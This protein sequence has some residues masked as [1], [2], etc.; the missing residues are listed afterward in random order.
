MEQATFITTNAYIRM[1]KIKDQLLKIEQTK[2]QIK[3]SKGEQQRQY[4]KCLH[5]LQKELNL[6][7]FY[8]GE[9]NGKCE[10]NTDTRSG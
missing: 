1:I 10:K 7:Y 9:K 6:C 5:R 8:L 3:N 2:N 4:K